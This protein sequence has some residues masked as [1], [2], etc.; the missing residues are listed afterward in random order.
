VPDSAPIVPSKVAADRRG[1]LVQAAYELIAAE[2]FERLRTREVAGRV[3]INIATLHYYF[4][5]KEAL[6]AAVA[7]H[8]SFQFSTIR[9][10][11]VSGADPTALDR[12]RQEFADSRF[13]ASERPEMVVV[14][15]ELALRARRD[16]AVAA[17]VE[18]L[19]RYWR[20]SIAETVQAGLDEGVFNPGL[21]PEAAAGVI[22]AALWGVAT[23]PLDPG[24][25]EHVYAA[26]EQW[27]APGHGSSK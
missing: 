24:E 26:I 12:L 10:P 5:T 7:E 6:I 16:P 25:R 13:Y 14:M 20:A 17:V 23:L 15:Q 19:K 4:P 21:D 1:A 11:S 2:G 8:L 3:G 18:P 22:A 27:L 9:A